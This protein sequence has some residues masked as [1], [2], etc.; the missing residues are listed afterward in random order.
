MAPHPTSTIILEVISTLNLNDIV[1]ILNVLWILAFLTFLLFTEGLK[2]LEHTRTSSSTRS[3]LVFLP[4]TVGSCGGQRRGQVHSLTRQPLLHVA[5]IVQSLGTIVQL[6]GTFLAI[7]QKQ[8]CE[9]RGWRAR[10]KVRSGSCLLI[11]HYTI[12]YAYI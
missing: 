3:P 1:G 8:Q 11:T 12:H 6:L 2:T 4:V 5:I 10:L 9:G 7:V